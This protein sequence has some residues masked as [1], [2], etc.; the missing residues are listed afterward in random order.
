MKRNPSE[1]QSHARSGL[2]AV[3]CLCATSGHTA[4]TY[5]CDYSLLCLCVCVC[6]CIYR[7]SC[8]VEF[9]PPCML[10]PSLHCHIDTPLV[11]LS[12]VTPVSHLPSAL[13]QRTSCIPPLLS[14]TQ[15]ML[16]FQCYHFVI[17][18]P[19]PCVDIIFPCIS[20]NSNERISREANAYWARLPCQTIAP[21]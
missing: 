8:M 13:T 17:H 7:Y 6:V 16:S 10:P 20:G 14:F 18:A 1:S 3:A 12:G 9:L 11:G 15:R 19:L 2:P 4:C 21:G 5:R